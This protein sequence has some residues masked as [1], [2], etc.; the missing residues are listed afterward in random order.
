MDMLISDQHLKSQFK[1]SKKS[2]KS[3]NVDDDEV[4]F[5]YIAFLPIHGKLWKLD[6][7][8]RQPQD[9]GKIGH[10]NWLDA[11]RPE[12]EAR[13]AA[14]EDNQIEFSILGVVR[15]PLSEQIPSLAL[16]IK[17]LIAVEARMDEHSADCPDWRDSTIQMET[18]L[19]GPDLSYGLDAETFAKASVPSQVAE[20]Y[21]AAK[22]ADIRH[23]RQRLVDKQDQIRLAI[24]DEQE[25]RAMDQEKAAGRRHD[26]GPAI[27]AWIKFHAERGLVKEFI[28]TS[29]ASD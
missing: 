10:R 3:K 1:D 9:L 13:M 24:K 15:D 4:G 29:K 18:T 8:E 26:Y 19:H 12:I 20:V 23:L 22:G 25:S 7:L 11:A 16:N 28:E 21:K 14:S 5:H 17:N 6:G 27:Q 2:K